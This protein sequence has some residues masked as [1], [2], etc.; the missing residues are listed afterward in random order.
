V[1]TRLSPQ[2]TLLLTA[3]RI[4]T[5]PTASCAIGCSPSTLYKR[6]RS[7]AFSPAMRVG[8]R[9][10]VSMPLLER[11]LAGESPTVADY[12]RTMAGLRAIGVEAN[13]AIRAVGRARVNSSRSSPGTFLPVASAA[14][15]DSIAGR[16]Q[17]GLEGDN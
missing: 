3:C 15:T 7:G 8:N 10:Y 11:H 16:L 4:I 14:S 12:N 9:W 13:L 17:A 2:M 5:V 6:C 1:N